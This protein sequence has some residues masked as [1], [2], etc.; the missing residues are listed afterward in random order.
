MKVKFIE[1]QDGTAFNWGKFMLCRF[2][3]AEW[4]YRA[5]IDG[6]HLLA[7]QGWSPEHVLV[8]DLATG[9]GAIFC[10]KGLA[11]YDLNEKHQIWVCPMYEPFLVWLYGQDTSDLDALPGMVNL[12]D[13]PTSLSGYRRKRAA[14]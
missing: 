1:A 10:P 3:E 11:T 14:G 4:A 2:D 12:G 7:G 5:Q 8:L 13:V 6:H 9:E